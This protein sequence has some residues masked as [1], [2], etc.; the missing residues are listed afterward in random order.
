MFIVVAS[1]EKEDENEETKS[2][3]IFPISCEPNFAPKGQFR[4]HFTTVIYSRN[5]LRF[6]GH[7]SHAVVV[8]ILYSVAKLIFPSFQLL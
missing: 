6:T 5:M 1:E 8:F 2:G 4:Q 3:P 7:C